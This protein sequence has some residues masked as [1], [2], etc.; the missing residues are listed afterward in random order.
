[1]TEV[2]CQCKK[3]F[4]LDWIDSDVDSDSQ[5]S[6]V[7]GVTLRDLERKTCKQQYVNLVLDNKVHTI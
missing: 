4:G 3:I 7:M 6:Y 5:S 2:Q 1:M